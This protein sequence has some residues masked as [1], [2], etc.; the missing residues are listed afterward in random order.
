MPKEPKDFLERPPIDI[1]LVDTETGETYSTWSDEAPLW[2]VIAASEAAGLSMSRLVLRS[3]LGKAMGPTVDPN[4]HTLHLGETEETH[5]KINRANPLIRTAENHFIRLSPS[6]HRLIGSLAT[7]PNSIIL[8]EELSGVLN[9][10]TS[11]GD[12]LHGHMSR[13]RRKLPEPYGNCIVTV[14]GDG[15]MGILG[16]DPAE[17]DGTLDS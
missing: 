11:S 12:V 14:K 17:L 4:Q 10:P 7:R 8:S 13:M 9:H 3:T 6:E 16:F 15:Y 5:L 1:H 2:S